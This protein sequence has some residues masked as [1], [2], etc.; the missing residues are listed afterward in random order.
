MANT[1][2]DKSK[3]HFLLLEGVHQSA[4]DTLTAEGYTNI[5]YLKTALPEDQLIEKIKTQMEDLPEL[6]MLKVKG[7]A[8][9]AGNEEADYLAT[10]AVR[11]ES[12]TRRERKKRG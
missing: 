3:I 7:H 2:L 6:E 1:S 4:V 12:S 10:M 5:E 8:G 11:R 9:Q